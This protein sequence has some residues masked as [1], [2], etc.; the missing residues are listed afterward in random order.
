LRQHRY[1]AADPTRSEEDD[2]RLDEIEA[3]L[4]EE[5]VEPD[6]PREPRDAS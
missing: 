2:A 3:K 6:F 1:L 5:G 4:R